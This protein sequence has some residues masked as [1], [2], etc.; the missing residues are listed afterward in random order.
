[1]EKQLDAIT[2]LTK[3]FEQ[4][5]SENK[6]IIVLG[7]ANLCSTKWNDHDFKLKIVAEE[8]KSTLAQCGMVNIELGHTYLADRMSKEGLPIQSSLDHI[9]MSDELRNCVTSKKTRYL[10]Y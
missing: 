9:Y 6:K 3:Q 4:A 8:I 2:I 10:Q 5:D 7:D 1:M